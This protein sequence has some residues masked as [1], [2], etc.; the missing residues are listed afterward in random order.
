[1]KDFRTLKV[2]HEAHSFTIAVYKIT[3]SFPKD[4]IFGLTSQFRRAST[5]IGLNIAEGCG[6]G[7]DPD[8][9]RFLQIAFGSACETEYCIILAKD[10]NY[11]SEESADFLMNQIENIK[12]MLSSLI[13]R[14]KN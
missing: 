1:M 7:T 13:T 10:L 12:K 14:L 8:F 2:W 5:S 9:K 3:S 11:I 6:R 4:E